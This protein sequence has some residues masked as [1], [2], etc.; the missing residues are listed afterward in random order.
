MSSKEF[1]KYVQTEIATWG[2]IA[3]KVLPK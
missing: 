1:N 2:P 3:I